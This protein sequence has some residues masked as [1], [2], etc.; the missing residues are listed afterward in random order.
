MTFTRFPAIHVSCHRE[1]L[2]HF[3]SPLPSC[4]RARILWGRRH[5]QTGEGGG[6]RAML[7]VEIATRVSLY[8]SAESSLAGSPDF[9]STSGAGGGCWTTKSSLAC[10]VEVAA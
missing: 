1:G 4:C 10:C 2:R 8:R 6:G 7:T 5:W 9:V 3:L